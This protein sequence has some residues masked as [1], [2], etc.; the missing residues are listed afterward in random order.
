M[1]KQPKAKV[2]QVRNSKNFRLKLFFIPLTAFL[3][4]MIWIATTKDHG[5]L[6]ADGENYLKAVEGIWKD[7]IFSTETNL[8]YWPA[9]YSIFLVICS[10]VSKTAILPLTAIIQ[11]LIYLFGCAY[12]VDQLRGTRIV[13]FA[14]PVAF[15]LAFNPLSSASKNSSV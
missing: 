11:S 9:G 1:A 7:G 13:K 12:F 2:K 14:Y 15:I 8:H 10:L 4:K 5:M 6:G 3:I